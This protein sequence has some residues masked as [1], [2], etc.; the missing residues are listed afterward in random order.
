MSTKTDLMLEKMI[1]GASWEELKEDREGSAANFYKALESYWVKIGEKYDETVKTI[2]QAEKKK[3][4]LEAEN[5]VLNSEVSR[6]RVEAKRMRDDT[7]ARIR[8]LG[9][10]ED[11][12]KGKVGLRD[13]IVGELTVLKDRGVTEDALAKIGRVNFGSSDELLARISTAEKY[14]ELTVHNQNRAK[15]NIDLETSNRI[16]GENLRRLLASCHSE[17]IKLSDL[18]RQGLIYVDQLWFAAKIFDKGYSR[19]MLTSLLEA[20]DSLTVENQRDAGMSHLLEALREA[21]DLTTLTTMINA[22]R[23][24]LAQTEADLKTARQT[25]TMMR[26]EFIT[27]VGKTTEKANQDLAA[28]MK[29]YEDEIIKW[30]NIKQEAGR[31]E[32][33]IKLAKTLF[34]L[35]ND[36]QAFRSLPLENVALLTR[37]INLYTQLRFKGERA[38]IPQTVSH[39]EVSFNTMLQYKISAVS[40]WLSDFYTEKE[41]TIG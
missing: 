37:R 7:D 29:G 13:R 26:D 19:P 9:E 5:T 24:T 27:A 15:E 3:S 6:L 20:L 39:I 32:A 10:L 30:G 21:K 4:D 22:N 34:G 25:L 17:D 33:D 35:M 2:K 28:L 8:Q 11:Q 16:A 1:K 14:N 31:Y 23:A 18:H 38:A 41:G 36:P 12:I 40:Q